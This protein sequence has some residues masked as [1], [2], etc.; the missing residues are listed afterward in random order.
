MDSKKVYRLDVH[1]DSISIAV[2]NGAGKIVMESAIVH[3]SGPRRIACANGFLS[4][5]F[6]F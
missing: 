3:S 6:F 1:K 2:M 4:H 5:R